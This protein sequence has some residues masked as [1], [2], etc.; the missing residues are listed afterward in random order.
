[1]WTKMPVAGSE[2][3]READECEEDDGSSWQTIL[4][5]AVLDAIRK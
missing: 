1:M 5:K 3:N 4:T 2:G